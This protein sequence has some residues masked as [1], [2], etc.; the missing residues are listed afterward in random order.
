MI[1]MKEEGS[2]GRSVF[3]SLRLP[4]VNVETTTSVGWN[5]FNRKAVKL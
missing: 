3:N 5:G 2:R 1:F 4:N